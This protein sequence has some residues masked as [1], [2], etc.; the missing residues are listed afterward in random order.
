[1]LKVSLRS[2]LESLKR[3]TLK[4]KVTREFTSFK[5]LSKNYGDLYEN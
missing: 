4:F 5:T 2:T 1:V 3:N